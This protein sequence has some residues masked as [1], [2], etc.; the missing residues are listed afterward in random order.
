M[1]TSFYFVLWIGLYFLIGV[2]GNQ[3][4]QYNSFFVAIVAVFVISSILSKITINQRAYMANRDGARFFELLY[5]ND[6]KRYLALHHRRLLFNVATFIYFMITVI[7]LLMIH[8]SWVII[9]IF[10]F[11]GFGSANGMVESYKVYSHVRDAGAIELDEES[12]EVFNRYK[13]GRDA[14][15]KANQM[16][17]PATWKDKL[18]R[19]SNIG[20]AIISIVLGIIYI[21]MYIPGLLSHGT[22]LMGSTMF[23][24][25]GGL[26]LIYGINDLTTTI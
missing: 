9:A 8:E 16:Y 22:Y 23:I 5:K 6:Y 18:F 1:K 17:P 21:G 2:F 19:G 12:M 25:Y 26:A 14:G 15:F 3:W 7:F 10:A 13:E 4:M 20:F 11:F 24:A